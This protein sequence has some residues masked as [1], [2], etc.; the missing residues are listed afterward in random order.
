M[1][2]NVDLNLL[3]ALE[4]I[5]DEQ[6]VTK[7]AARLGLSQ[8]AMSAS[9]G[10]LRRHFGD[11]LLTRVGNTYE[12]TPLARE[13]L[14]PTSIALRAASRVFFRDAEFDP[15]TSTRTFSVV[16][17]D[18]STAVLG[19][20]LAR[21]FHEESPD[22]R[23]YIHGLTPYLV[24]GAPESM[25]SQDLVVM[26]HG[27]LA[28]MPHQDVYE[29]D[30]ACIVATDNAEV[31]SALT[32]DDLIKMPWVLTF[33]QRTAFTTAV[34]QLRM[35]GVEPRVEIVTENYLSVGPL[36]AGSRRVAIVQERLAQMLAQSGMVRVLPCPFDADPLV[37]TIWWH[38][39]YDNDPGHR[40]LRGLFRQ[41]GIEIQ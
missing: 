25:R 33:H 4:A 37:E 32:L 28:D 13:L 18:Y 16:M 23:L 11:E 5:L 27:F 10:K 12:P 22:A 17:S 2:H 21:R 34:Q 39:M 3:R 40:W 26:P 20:A 30:W 1:T 29:D 14:G 36:V 8:P 9:L 7:A 35:Q 24:D 41:A 15:A 38:P 19:A 31:G 6:S